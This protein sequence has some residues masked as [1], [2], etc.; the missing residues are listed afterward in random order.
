MRFLALALTFIT[1]YTTAFSQFDQEQLLDFSNQIQ[2][3]ESKFDERERQLRENIDIL[4]QELEGLKG[5]KTNLKNLVLRI[6][7]L[8]K[9]QTNFQRINEE[10]RNKEVELTQVRYVAGLLV[11]K[12]MIEFLYTLRS[13]YSGLDFQQSYLNLSNPNSYPSYKNNMDHLKRKLAKNNLNLPDLDMDN[14]FLNVAYGVGRALVSSTEDKTKRTKELMCILDFTSRASV[15]LRIA[16]YDIKFLE[17]ELDKMII[18]FEDLF[19]SYTKQVG[20]SQSFQQY[21]KND[22]DNLDAEIIPGYFTKL[23][24]AKETD[25]EK[26]LR[27]LKFRLK[28]IIDAYQE[29]ELFIRKGLAYYEKFD[30]IISNLTPKYDQATV[31]GEIGLHFQL[32]K[33]KLVKAKA[34]FEN[35]YKG[36]IKQS[37]IRQLIDG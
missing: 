24:S 6:E 35:A 12:D 22:N 31:N 29:Y 3:I 1:C 7:A 37:Y 2:G 11:I 19:K 33:S 18:N 4:N 9:K 5:D 17:S 34:D 20:Y 23:M 26:S 28:K 32:M 21:I 25:R 30:N 10:S 27:D 13:Q 8:E 15:E 14:V 36:K 16:N